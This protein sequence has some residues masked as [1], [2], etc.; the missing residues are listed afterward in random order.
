[1][2]MFLTR[3]GL[4]SKAV[5]I[6]DVTQIDL[7]RGQTSGL[8]EARQILSDA[9]EIAVC[10]FDQRDVVRHQLVKLIIQAYEKV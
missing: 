7:P 2:K 3:I 6:G 1:M 9:K 10:E 4:N 5:V 8:I